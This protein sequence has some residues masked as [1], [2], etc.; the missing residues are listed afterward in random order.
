M[1]RLFIFSN[2]LFLSIGDYFS[3]KTNF[4]C[5]NILRYF[6]T[7]PPPPLTLN[8]SFLKIGGYIVDDT[9]SEAGGGA[10]CMEHAV[11][12]EIQ[13]HYNFSISIQNP[14]TPSQGMCV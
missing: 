2:L 8:I 11:N 5:P 9:G 14:V 10:I 12:A 6:L 7:P 1:C 13:K 4:E 3:R